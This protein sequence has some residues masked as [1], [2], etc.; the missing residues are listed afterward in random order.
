MCSH[1]VK[2]V[3][4]RCAFRCSSL[5]WHQTRGRCA[6]ATNL[7]QG[8][9]LLQLFVD[10]HF[11]SPGHS[12]VELFNRGVIC[13]YGPLGTELR[14]N[15]L[16]Q[17]WR[18]ITGSREQVFGINTP[19]SRN[20]SADAAGERWGHPRVLQP[21]D[22]QENLK[23]TELSGEQLAHNVHMFLQRA[24]LFRTNLI[25]A[26]EQFVPLFELVNRKLPF[27]IA[28]TGRCFQHSK[29]GS[30]CPDE[31]TQAS[32]V[33]FCS[34]R[35][36][37]QWLDHWVRQRLRW[38]RKFSLAPSDFSSSDLPQEE[39]EGPV[40]RGVQI[41]YKFPWGQEPLEFVS[42]RGDGEL[43]QMHRGAR[44][45]L[46]S[47]DGRKSIPHVLSITGNIDRGLLAFLSNSLQLHKREDAKQNLQQRK[48]LKLHPLLAPVK[49]AIGIGR[50]ATM[51]LRQVCEGLLQELK[52]AK[53]SAWPGY[54]ETSPTPMEQLNSKYDEMGV[55]FT[56]VISE[57][58]LES[59]LVQ[60]R[61]RDTTI[62]ETMHISEL[63]NF[64]CRYI[65][66]ADNM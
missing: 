57:N 33:W 25:Q 10:R 64:L 28:E 51:E 5:I 15:V 19:S 65:S 17:W 27:G 29:D 36:S 3:T 23:D 8:R 47:R 24:P 34:P 41:F 30:G 32:L 4:L 16:H 45:K 48:V 26:L 39:L 44:S 6:P 14:E 50:G 58:T 42:S 37:S 43:L 12:N 18:S 35:T 52:E 62:K 63:S 56:V 31:T 22:F 2:S 40:S 7:D 11:I 55:L 60:L 53:I 21:E 1:F 13:S 61:S 59:G 54:L 9:T 49:V 66:A 20:V 38:W 46:Q